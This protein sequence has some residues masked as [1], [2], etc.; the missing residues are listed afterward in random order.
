[1]WPEKIN[2]SESKLRLSLLVFCIF[3]NTNFERFC[4]AITKHYR[5]KLQNNLLKHPAG[6]FA[7]ISLFCVIIFANRPTLYSHTSLGLSSY[8]C[9]FAESVATP[10]VRQQTRGCWRCLVLVLVTSH[11]SKFIMCSLSTSQMLKKWI[12]VPQSTKKLF[13]LPS[14]ARNKFLIPESILVSSQARKLQRPVLMPQDMPACTRGWWQ[15]KETNPHRK[16]QCSWMWHRMWCKRREIFFQSS[17]VTVKT[18]SRLF[19]LN[20]RWVNFGIYFDVRL[21]VPSALDPDE[22][23]RTSRS[24]REHCA[25]RSSNCKPQL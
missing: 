4:F 23:N 5:P 3:A 11:M 18:S 1:M 2:F 6:V 24:A 8:S 21:R 17:T 10:L 20:Q 13:L 9:R 22:R 14:P 15:W 7:T 19:L 25:S 12:F 16:L